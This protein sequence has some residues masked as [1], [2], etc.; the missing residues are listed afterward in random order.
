L[1]SRK[2]DI[3]VSIFKVR[4]LTG[5]RR[6]V[7]LGNPGMAE[8]PLC[9]CGM[10]ETEIFRELPA[11]NGSA[12]QKPRN[13]TAF[14]NASPQTCSLAFLSDA[15]KPLMCGRAVILRPRS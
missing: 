3:V 8:Y 13:A 12:P 14:A 11:K 9:R 5:W 4:T 7:F 6:G 2:S 10:S 15:A 1:G